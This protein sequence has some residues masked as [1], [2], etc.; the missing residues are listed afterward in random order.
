[1]KLP[2]LIAAFLALV[3]QSALPV[4]AQPPA[5]AYY[6]HPRHADDIPL[7]RYAE[8]RGKVLSTMSPKSLAVF[9]AAEVRNRQNDV[10]YEYRQ[11]SDFWYLCG[12]PESESSL[13]LIPG[14]IV[15]PKTLD[16]T[17]TRHDALLFVKKRDLYLEMRSGSITGAD[18]AKSMYGIMALENVNFA[19]V[20][21][22]LLQPEDSTLKRD[23]VFVTTFPTSA[24][25]EPLS[26]EA[27]NIERESR[28]R[29]QKQYP[30]AVIRSQKRLLADMRQIKDADELRL[31]R[32]AIDISLAG[33]REA[34]AQTKP[35]AY[36]YEIEA[37]MEGAFKRLGAE[38]VGYPSIIGA[39]ANSC[40]LH[41]TFSRRQAEA[42]EVLLMDC[43]AEYHGYTADITRTI[44]VSGKFSPEQREIYNLVY[45]AQEAAIKEYRKGVDW[46][47]PHSKAVDIIRTGLIKLG[48]I[49]NPDDYKLYFPHGSVHYIGLDVHDAGNYATFQPNMILTCEPGI[50]IPAGSACDKKWWN[51]GVRIED[52]VLVTDGEPVIVS[53]ALPRT[54][55][56]IEAMMKAPATQP[57][58]LPSKKR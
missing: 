48:V 31:L 33:H 37:A 4:F 17:G 53:A 16:S 49:T 29:L 6:L 34:I 23:T 47:L 22:T 27:V 1:M 10:D 19:S 11:S 55:E 44:P 15:L 2:V 45:T 8:R 46:R 12:F 32:K 20:L 5:A 40:I 3:C 57:I 42:G 50:Y 54:A 18:R 21:G 51:I 30:R 43:G 9:S 58:K 7:S 38:D 56:G 36:E 25:V 35:K 41:Y 14:G 26:G 28:L 24:V 39:G 13:V 52:D